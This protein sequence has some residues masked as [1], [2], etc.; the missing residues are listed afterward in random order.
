MYCVL[1]TNHAKFAKETSAIFETFNI[2]KC[3]RFFGTE[4]VFTV[5]CTCI[6]FMQVMSIWKSYVVVIIMITGLVAPYILSLTNQ[7]FY[8]M[9]LNLKTNALDITPALFEK[10]ND[11]FS[12]KSRYKDSRL[13]K[14]LRENNCT[15]NFTRKHLMTMNLDG[16]T[17]NRLFELATLIATAASLCYTPVIDIKEVEC[18]EDLFDIFNVKRLELDKSSFRE[19][20]EPAAGTYDVN[21]TSRIDPAYNWTLL[22]YRQS[23]KYFDK[24]GELIRSS[25]R[26]KKKFRTHVLRYLGSSYNAQETVGLHVRRGDFVTE[27]SRKFGFSVSTLKYINRA[28]T[29]MRNRQKKLDVL[30]LLL[31]TISSGV[32][33]I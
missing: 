2:K 5:C 21:L 1:R 26:I 12:P 25:F 7:R 29:Y 33:P 32:K 19:L 6:I 16:R 8:E 17:G 27:D 4:Y 23:F 9:S 31:V 11:I 28:I 13:P 20:S 18:F 14:I 3:T 22:G 10:G 30:L 15:D 24:Y